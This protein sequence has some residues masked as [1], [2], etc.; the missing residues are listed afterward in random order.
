MRQRNAVTIIQCNR[1]RM[2]WKQRSCCYLQWAL[3]IEQNRADNVSVI[4]RLVQTRSHELYFSHSNWSDS[5]EDAS[6]VDRWSDG[7]CLKTT[8]WDL[9]AEMQ[10]I[11][12]LLWSLKKKRKTTCNQEQDNK[13]L[14]F[15]WQ[16]HPFPHHQLFIYCLGRHWENNS[17]EISKIPFVRSLFLPCEDLIAIHVISSGPSHFAISAVCRNTASDVHEFLEK[18]AFSSWCL[19]SACVQEPPTVENLWPHWSLLE[20]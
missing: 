12:G 7:A 3:Y 15:L 6:N 19:S 16:L 13:S 9:G 2:S 5:V 14:T 4:N 1:S 8:P 20:H 10:Y 11:V 17:W 18:S